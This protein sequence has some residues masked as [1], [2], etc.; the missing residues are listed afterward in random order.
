V[1]AR[2]NFTSNFMTDFMAGE[3]VF[4]VSEP[5]VLYFSAG[6]SGGGGGYQPIQRI[7]SHEAAVVFMSGKALWKYYHQQANCNVNASLYDIREHFQGRNE[8]GKMNNSSEDETYM[9]LIGDLRKKVNLLAKKIE[10][11][12]YEYGFLK[13]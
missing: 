2:D 9:N 4:V 1:A 3:S 10:P 12:V 7:F 13:N 8:N 11:K 6:N 5:Q